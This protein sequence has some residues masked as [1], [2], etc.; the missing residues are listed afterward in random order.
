MTDTMIK[1]G[2]AVGIMPQTKGMEEEDF[3]TALQVLTRALAS[4]EE[5]L[6]AAQSLVQQLAGSL[7]EVRQ[8]LLALSSYASPPPQTALA[9]TPGEYAQLHIYCFGAFEVYRGSTYIPQRRSGKGSAILKYLASRPR[10][11]VQRDVLLEVL[12]PETAPRI[13]NNRLKVAVHHLRQTFTPEVAGLNGEPMIL[14]QDGYYLF[15]PQIRVWT[16]VEAFKLNWQTGLRLE[17]AGRLAEAVP[18]YQQ[19]KTLYRGDFLEDDPFEEWTL[20]QREELRDTYLMI[21][22]KLSRAWFQAGQLDR[23]V[24]GWKKI[25]AMDPWREDA[26]RH[27]MVCYSQSRQ[28]ELALHWYALCLQALRDQ[29]GLGPAAET[30]AL[31]EHIRAGERVDA[32]VD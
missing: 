3:H 26:Y 4:L 9:T 14:F 13:A 1:T 30:V 17:R 18:F 15:N 7:D 21:L 29:L 12:W 2:R 10:Q 28:R 6:Y 27:L 5:N 19:A 16:D 22:D 23:A 31:Y 24:E 11:P 25:I 8:R 20:A 32:L